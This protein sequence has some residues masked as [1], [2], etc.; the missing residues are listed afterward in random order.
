MA[1]VFACSKAVSYDSAT[2]KFHVYL[3]CGAVASSAHCRVLVP[4]FG[5]FCKP[6]RT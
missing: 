2:D 6:V 5:M 3:S 4:I 1:I